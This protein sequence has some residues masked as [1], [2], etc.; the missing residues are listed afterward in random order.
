M[1]T[2]LGL[3]LAAGLVSAASSFA[4]A[5]STGAS[6]DRDI[7]IKVCN[8]TSVTA[9]IATDY[10]P[11]KYSD[12]N[13]WTN[14]G[15]FT[16][17]AGDCEIVAHTGNRIFYLRGEEKGGS[18]FWAGEYGHC[19]VYPGPYKIQEDAKADTCTSGGE[20]KKFFRAVATADSGVYTWTLTP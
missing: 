7:S 15:W 11:V 19:V 9:L 4:Q 14:E 17:E 13:W 6:L 2:K 8:K 16:V 5:D 1:N 12:E 18:Q 10:L 20:A 3:M